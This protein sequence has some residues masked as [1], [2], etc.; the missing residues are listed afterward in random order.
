[1][2]KFL[3]LTAA[4][5]ALA[6]VLPAVETQTWIQSQQEE[7]TK[8]TVEN[9]SIR[10]DGRVT[11][12]PSF[13]EIFDPSTA[14]LW[15]LARDSK[16]NLYAGGGGPG[17]ASAKLFLID[18]DGKGKAL[19]ELPALEIHAIAIDKKD[20]VYAATSPDG[21]VYRVNGDGSPEVFYDPKAKYIWGMAF[22]GQGDL[23]IVTGDEGEIHRVK[24]DG[25]GSIFFRTEETHARSLAIDGKDNLIVG[26]EPGGLILRISPAGD[27]F[28]MY[29]AGK[30]E[31][32][33]VAVSP[34][35]TIYAAAVGSKPSTPITPP[36]AAPKPAPSAQPAPPPV[37]GMGQ[38]QGQR[39]APALPPALSPVTSAGIS[40]GSEVYR[41]DP[42]GQPRK[43]WTNSREV[44]YAIAFDGQGRPI[45]GTGNK[46]NIYRL[47]DD[48]LSTQLLNSPP[49][50]VTSF[51]AGTHGSI[52]AV[53]GNLGKV[54]R[55]GPDQEKE[56]TLESEVLDAGSFSDWGRLAW[57]G[58]QNGG[59]VT[60]ESRSGNLDRPQKNWSPW[61]KLDAGPASRVPSPSARFLQWRMTMAGA[62]GGAS[63]SVGLVEVAYQPRNIAPV[64]SIIDITPFNYRFPAQSLTLTPSTNITLPPLGN[65]RPA[66]TGS[67]STSSSQSMLFGKGSI[68]ARWLADDD[69]GDDIRS[70]VEIRGV[71]EKNW[72]LLK[73]DVEGN[74]YSWDSTAFPDGEYV[75]RVTVTDAPD[76]PPAGA[77]TAQLE[78]DPFVIDNTPP[79]ITGLTL[80]PQGQKLVARWRAVD[81]RNP[82]ERAEYSLNGGEWQLVE[83]TTHLT[84][85]LMHEYQLTVD[86][87][88]QGETTIAVRVTDRFDN[89]AVVSALAR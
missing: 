87:P 53:T 81:A 35:G 68:G 5:A 55:I 25:K 41:I 24:P 43:V 46:G 13:T 78:S 7:F 19:A 45:L 70:K 38:Q 62:A 82:I 21:K 58:E 80:T 49:T 33:A 71:R 50:Q 77:L 2:N 37:G 10:S 89:H 15:A 60:F 26:T 72:K 12:A 1:M 4:L 79:E 8:G 22:N 18:R 75:V 42:D 28:V 56:G 73:D 31:V 34:S 86:R 48:L 20:S 88:G 63:P 11:L 51:T 6:G 83:P 32:T 67:V 54:Y 17:S 27:G 30:R 59:A 74:Q 23:F 57:K 40:G 61:G 84:D 85:S 3:S 9:L 29:Q 66:P 65:R 14:Y 44:V 36:P 52:Y 39:A 16:G 69:N 76:N 64:V 47:D